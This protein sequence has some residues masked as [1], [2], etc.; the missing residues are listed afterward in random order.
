MRNKSFVYLAIC[1]K[2]KVKKHRLNRS[3][4]A[5]GYS[6]GH[7]KSGQDETWIENTPDA[8]GAVTTFRG[9]LIR[10]FLLFSRTLTPPNPTNTLWSWKI[11]SYAKCNHLLHH[12][13]PDASTPRGSPCL[14]SHPGPSS[15]LRS[16]SQTC[17]RRMLSGW[18][19]L[20]SYFLPFCPSI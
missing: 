20:W 14:A 2:T 11:E 12:A 3:V 4:E 16:V 10:L 8:H 19:G 13:S 17:Q 7:H 9:T 6:Q 1:F 15:G 18:L 5:S